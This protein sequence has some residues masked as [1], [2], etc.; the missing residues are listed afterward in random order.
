MI[1]AMIVSA[2]PESIAAGQAA[3]SYSPR[4]ACVLRRGT[5][6]ARQSFNGM[7]WRVDTKDPG[8][9][10]AADGAATPL[11]IARD[12]ALLNAMGID[13]WLN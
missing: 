3:K 12:A 9:G 13:Q 2:K 7:T 6:R 10:R 11:G 4:R 5:C 1:F 8:E